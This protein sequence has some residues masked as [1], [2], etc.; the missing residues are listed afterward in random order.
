MFATLQMIYFNW[1][2]AACAAVSKETEITW[3]CRTL[4][5]SALAKNWLHTKPVCKTI[6]LNY[7]MAFMYGVHN[8]GQLNSRTIWHSKSNIANSDGKHRLE[9][10]T[11][12]WCLHN[13]MCT[14]TQVTTVYFQG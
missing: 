5:R 10:L 6:I 11:A 9:S 1:N 4:S 13:V 7:T 12:N 14:D 8:V 2:I 3:I